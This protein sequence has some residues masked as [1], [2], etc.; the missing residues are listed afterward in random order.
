MSSYVP[1]Q[2]FAS[3]TSRGSQQ[4]NANRGIFP[5]QRDNMFNTNMP[6]AENFESKET[7]KTE[8]MIKVTAVGEVSLPPDRCRVTIKIHSTKD[9]VQDVKNSIQR[10]LDY[11]LQT[12]QNHGV[13]ESDIQVHKSMRRAESMY[14]MTSEVIVVF[15]DFHKCQ[16][17]CNLLVEKLDE[18]VSVGM[19]E[20]YHA[21]TTLETLR[22]QAS[23]LAVHNAKQKAQEM[24]K[25]VH[26]AV[27]KPI[28]I[29][30]EESKEWE[31]QIEGVT[32]VDTQ[33]TVQQ[34]ISQATVTVS[35]RV[36]VTFELKPKVKTK[37]LK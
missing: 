8:R 14:D 31:G 6:N 2:V 4:Q 19:P 22:Q 9:N 28:S 34:R 16:T 10:R 33:P 27:G 32:D 35:C 5:Q 36:N 29:Q 20:Y 3:I 23:L 25:F 18:T 7:S 15:L 11:V 1:S 24:A 17:A 37:S 26:Q 13:K 12:L 30:E 21:G